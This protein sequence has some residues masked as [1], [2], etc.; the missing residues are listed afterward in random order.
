MRQ[1]SVFVCNLFGT[2]VKQR[3]CTLSHRAKNEV[4][5][6][7]I[8]DLVFIV[9]D[10]LFSKPHILVH[11]LSK[12]LCCLSVGPACPTSKTAGSVIYFTLTLCLQQ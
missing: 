3:Q 8:E 12:Q 6:S 11:L 5:V 10:A 7:S 2:A 4:L 9:F 1:G